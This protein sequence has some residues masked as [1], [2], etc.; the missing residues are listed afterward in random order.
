MI[1]K[2]GTFWVSQAGIPPLAIQIGALPCH[3]GSRR[4]GGA[5]INR[6]AKLGR[7]SSSETP[8][9]KSEV[10]TKARGSRNPL[11]ELNGGY[12]PPAHSREGG[13]RRGCFGRL[14]S[15][16]SSSSS[17]SSSR[18][19]ILPKSR[20]LLEP[21]RRLPQTREPP[22]PQEL[23]VAAW[24]RTSGGHFSRLRRSWSRFGKSGTPM[25]LCKIS[26]GSG[27]DDPAGEERDQSQIQNSQTPTSTRTGTPPVQA[28]I[29]PE[30]G[31]QSM[32]P[33]PACF[34]AGHLLTGVQDRRKCRPRGILNGGSS[35]L[36]IADSGSLGFHVCSSAKSQAS[37][38]PPPPLGASVRWLSS[39]GN[40]QSGRLEE[41]SSSNSRLCLAEASVSWFLSPKENLAGK[42]TV[43]NFSPNSNNLG[44]SGTTPWSNHH[45]L[46]VSP[47]SLTETACNSPELRGWLTP[48]SSNFEK[49]PPALEICRS[50]ASSSGLSPF[51]MIL[52][53]AS[54]M[55]KCHY[56]SSAVNSPF[57]GDSHGNSN[58]MCT[59]SSCSSPSRQVGQ[60]D[61]FGLHPMAEEAVGNLCSS[62]PHQELSSCGSKPALPFSTQSFHFGCPPTPLS[63]VD[64]SC[65]QRPSCLQS[66]AKEKPQFRG[67]NSSPS[68]M[69]ISW[70]EGLISRIFDMHEFTHSFWSPEK[71]D[72]GCQE[73]DQ[74]TSELHR[75]L[76]CTPGSS[77]FTK[78]NELNA[79]LG[80][81]SF[82]FSG[83]EQQ[84]EQNSGGEGPFPSPTPC[85]ES[86]QID[87]HCL[88]ASDDS[89]WTLFFKNHLF[90]V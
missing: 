76:E 45:L 4:D 27:S 66:S 84:S 73:E 7:R 23:A 16:S 32:L 36:H 13:P 12:L 50:P 37:L 65:F 28:T 88:M 1:L 9:R 15:N 5:A 51:S 49:T 61:P 67:E 39:P 22:M 2:K 68:E 80:F 11:K 10:K 85:A 44:S 19:N 18:V 58:V 89:D 57:S 20:P 29:S 86:L 42:S 62:P 71:E 26:Y 52:Q 82:E 48:S 54:A 69:R 64:L 38:T 78:V 75:K 8:S 77:K 60:L 63:S 31:G 70:R 47:A 40:G 24:K 87:E 14:L 81:G 3:G 46:G 21:L 72:G 59:P 30:F 90:E 83:Y 79:A 43:Q 33:T 53:K 6:P 34:A 35:G 41:V 74:L 17:S 25:S 56:L 55:S